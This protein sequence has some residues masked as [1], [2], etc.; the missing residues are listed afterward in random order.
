MKTNPGL[1]KLLTDYHNAC[2]TLRAIMQGDDT[3]DGYGARF[4]AALAL[5]KTLRHRYEDAVREG[6]EAKA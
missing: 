2:D 3:V 6:Q 1:N 5:C 4:E